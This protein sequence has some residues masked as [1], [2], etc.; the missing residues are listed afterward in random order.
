MNESTFICKL[1]FHAVKK[2][3]FKTI[4]VREL[5][6]Y[7]GAHVTYAVMN[8]FLSI[9]PYFLS[10]RIFSLYYKNEPIT[11]SDIGNQYQQKIL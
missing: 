10:F 5:R 1:H 7:T 4:D 9:V 6:D 11:T 2:L 3:K 8:T